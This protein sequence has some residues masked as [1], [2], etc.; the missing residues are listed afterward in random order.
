[1]KTDNELLVDT[2]GLDDL[3]H[4]A[5]NALQ[6]FYTTHDVSYLRMACLWTEHGW[7]KKERMI[8]K[9]SDIIADK[10]SQTQRETTQSEA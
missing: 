3:L 10:T 6:R 5:R 8:Q 4:C 7:K 1:M 2:Y 9:Y